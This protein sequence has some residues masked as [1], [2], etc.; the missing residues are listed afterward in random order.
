VAAKHNLLIDQGSDWS[1]SLLWKDATGA[2]VDVDLYTA[3]MMI[4]RD[5]EVEPALLVLTTENSRVTLG[6][7]EETLGVP[8]YNI[9]LE[10]ENAATDDLP[11]GR[12]PYDLE[13]IAPG[14]F[15]RRL[16]QG[17][18]KVSREVTRPD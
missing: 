12:W 10:I 17:K 8:L 9:L 15:V 13:M 4:R 3:R 14:G 5:Y 2:P 7:V 6:L 11:A 1:Q 16:M 18:V